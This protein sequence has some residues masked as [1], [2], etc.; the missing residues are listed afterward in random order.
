M[1][2]S[3]S[4]IKLRRTFTAALFALGII[5]TGPSLQA[6]NEAWSTNTPG[7][8]DGNFSGTNWT[9]G[10][11]GV[12][13][14]TNAAASGDA[15][16]FDTSAITALTNDLSG[17]TFAGI[18]FNSVASAYTI[19]GNAFILGGN[20]TNSSTNLQTINNAIS[21]T[22]VRTVTTT[23]GG[24]DITLG[25]IIS[26]TGGITKAGSGTLT[27]SGANT[28]TGA[29][30]VNLGTVSVSGGNTQTLTG[31]IQVGS[32]LTAGATTVSALNISNNTTLGSSSTTF[33]GYVGNGTNSLGVIN[34]A[35]GST[36]SFTGAA[37]AG[38][39]IGNST[40]SAGA[41]FNSGSLTNTAAVSGGA[42]FF[43]GNAVGAYGY[44]QNSGTTSISARLGIVNGNT[45]AGVMDITGGTVTILGTNQSA[46]TAL[47][48]NGNGTGI[49]GTAALNITGGGTLTSANGA[50]A[51]TLTVNTGTGATTG[52]SSIN[53]TGAGSKLT[54]TPLSGAGGVLLNSGNIAAN[55]ATLTLGS[56]ASTG[57]ELDV[58][59]VN[60]NG[61]TA[62]TTMTFNGGT[63]KATGA[64][65]TGLIRTNVSTFVHAGGGTI[66]NGGFAVTVQS[67]LKAPVADGSTTF[68]V[69]G[70]N[71][72][73]TANNSFIGAPVVKFTGGGGTGAAGYAVFDAVNGKVTSIV[74]T[75]PG[76]GYTSAPTIT[77]VGGTAVAGN[78]AAAFGTT[79]TGTTGSVSSGGMTFTGSGTTTL[80]GANTY[81]GGTTVNVGTLATNSTGTFGTGNVSVVAGAALTFG[82]NASIADSATLTFADTSTINLSFSGAET[83][84]NVYNSVSATYLTAGTYTVSQ[85]NTYFGDSAFTG[86]GSFIVSAIPEPATYAA[87][88]G[89]LTLSIA[90]I[91]RRRQTTV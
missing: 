74:I 26:G 18:T 35:S 32:A 49:S 61:T 81:S 8:A 5:L 24:G 42:G 60:T 69:T 80:S 39:N 25:G 15:L 27:L 21:S 22:A 17:A 28:F 14:P 36:L 84:G 67:A 34:I 86:T 7:P 71:F 89:A 2:P 45:G 40:N 83:L 37:G 65:A 23:A 77:L 43:L 62:T 47:E 33:T 12:A 76:S 66:D 16:F 9:V 78:G 19:G 79:Y 30:T 52:Y 58:S 82:N 68:G 85:L 70:S 50:N 57:G 75:S 10:T 88:C 90:A 48:V 6:A 41:I 59:F 63:L 29:L 64:D 54:L 53:I 51:N 72:S 1:H 44:L 20:L 56:G 91:R 31:Q 55:V 11:T 4:Q 87:L 3:S 46:G 73:A 13:T 38:G